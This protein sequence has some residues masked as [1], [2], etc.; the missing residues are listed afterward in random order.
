MPV[1][2][3]PLDDDLEDAVIAIHVSSGK[4]WEDIAVL[5]KGRL[6]IGDRERIRRAVLTSAG[7]SIGASI[8]R[9]AGPKKEAEI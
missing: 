4:G 6:R 9:G 5:M 8:G 2:A 7:G 3:S 1:P